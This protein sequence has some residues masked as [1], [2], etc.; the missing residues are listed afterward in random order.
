MIIYTILFLFFKLTLHISTNKQISGS[1]AYTVLRS[2]QTFKR[3]AVWLHHDDQ[4]DRS[5]NKAT[6]IKMV[7]V[8]ED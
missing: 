5:V 1:P 4:A 8:S 3:L 7:H 6:I 2:K